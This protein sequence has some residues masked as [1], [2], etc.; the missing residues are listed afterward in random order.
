MVLSISFDVL[1]VDVS[2]SIFDDESS[3]E[4]FM[5]FSKDSLTEL[6]NNSITFFMWYMRMTIPVGP[7]IESFRVLFDIDS[8]M[9][10]A[11]DKAS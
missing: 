10:L 1:D 3:S 7:M 8:A 2:D 6:R 11:V 5:A 9:I 4:L